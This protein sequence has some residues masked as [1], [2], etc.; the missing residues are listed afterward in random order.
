MRGGQAARTIACGVCLLLMA[1]ADPRPVPKPCDSASPVGPSGCSATPAGVAGESRAVPNF[2][3]SWAGDFETTA[4]HE[5]DG[6]VGFC[7]DYPVGASYPVALRLVQR[8]AAVEG[9][10]ALADMSVQVRGTVDASG[11]LTLSDADMRLQGESVALQAA[12]F[13]VASNG[14]LRGTFRTVWT[15]D[16]VAGRAGFN[17]ELRFV[18]KSRT[19]SGRSPVPHG[20]RGRS[21]NR[22]G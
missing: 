10:V 15:R 13:S 8:D 2:Q 5:S 11:T 12:S 14:D 18:S 3:G 17:A 7:R 9:S 6:L 1:C 4:C 16:G 22:I 20:V 21:R 19:I